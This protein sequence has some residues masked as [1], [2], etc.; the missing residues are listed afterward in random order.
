MKK[1][2]IKAFIKITNLLL[3]VVYGFS[4]VYGDLVFVHKLPL[5][6]QVIPF[7]LFL[8]I[9]IAVDDKHFKDPRESNFTP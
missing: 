6:V 1:Q 4:L 8:G 5:I 2:K 7:F 9:E 3:A